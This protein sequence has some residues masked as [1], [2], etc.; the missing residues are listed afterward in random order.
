MAYLWVNALILP[1][2]SPHQGTCPLSDLFDTALKLRVPLVSV[3][4]LLTG[5]ALPLK[6]IGTGPFMLKLRGN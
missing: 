1:R 5:F 2:F 6:E 4:L 3:A